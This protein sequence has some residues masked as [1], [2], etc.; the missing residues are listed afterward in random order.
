MHY[1][2]QVIKILYTD[3]KI[4]W[5]EKHQLFSL[6]LYIASSAFIAYMILKADVAPRISISV[7]WII[8]GFGAVTST[9]R[10]L[11]RETSTRFLFYYQTVPP[12][13]LIVSKITFNALLLGVV[14]VFTAWLFDLLFHTQFSLSYL[15][16]IS[17]LG[18]LA[19]AS[20]L[21][22]IAGISA[23]VQGN[24][25]IMAVLSFPLLIPQLLVLI[26]ISEAM[27]IGVES[28]RYVVASLLLDL[29]TV[30]LSIVLFP[31]LWKE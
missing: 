9:S 4:E 14:S 17:L 19:F 30:A 27:L 24:A 6:F 7:F 22:L 21:T 10:S 12:S 29:I 31:F 18:A 13:L 2:K 28:T 26:R 3:F 11:I 1:I 8:L 16:G 25:A 23:A 20:T 15:L 5:R